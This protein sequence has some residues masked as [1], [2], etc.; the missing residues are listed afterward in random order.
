VEEDERS[1][2]VGAWRVSE[3]DQVN[4]GAGAVCRERERRFAGKRRIGRAEERTESSALSSS[5]LSKL[6][7]ERRSFSF[8][9]SAFHSLLFRADRSPVLPS[10]REA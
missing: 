5:I 8:S 10:L 4:V 3:E 7:V 6:G 1:E 2:E 9:L